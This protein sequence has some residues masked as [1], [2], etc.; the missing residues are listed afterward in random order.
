MTLTP[1]FNLS[2]NNPY[3]YTYDSTQPNDPYVYARLTTYGGWT[4]SY[5]PNTLP[6]QHTNDEIILG[7][8]PADPADENDITNYWDDVYRRSA[9]YFYVGTYNV[10][11]ASQL[12]LVFGFR[13]RTAA[14]IQFFIGP[15]FVR[16]EPIRYNTDET[17]A[18]TIDIPTTNFGVAVYA[19]LASASW[20]ARVGV[21]GVT[22]YL[23]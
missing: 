18:L 7:L 15:D 19:R 4:T 10:P 12:L 22:G 16:S 9:A 8:D 5:D 2:P 20:G 3:I 13:G 1:F 17:V 23:I 6:A 21:L 14:N 11:A